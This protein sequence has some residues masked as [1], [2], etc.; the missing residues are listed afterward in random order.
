MSKYKPRTVKLEKEDDLLLKKICSLNGVAVSTFMRDAILEKLAAGSV[1]NIAGKNKI[2]YHPDTDSFSWNIEP[3]DGKEV[4][5]LRNLNL[6][7]IQD[8]SANIMLQIQKRND[9][10]GKKNDKSVAV[11]KALVKG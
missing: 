1:S 6:E 5:V 10:L 8:L 2:Q 11:P 3:D 7:F 9:T 4:E